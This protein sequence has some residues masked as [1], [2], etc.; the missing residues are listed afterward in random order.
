MHIKPRGHIWRLLLPLLVLVPLIAAYG[1]K[2]Q[3]HQRPRPVIA[4]TI[5]KASR[6]QSGRIFLEHAQEVR[7]MR[8]DSFMVLVGDVLFT[9][10]PMRMSCDSAHYYPDQESMNAFGNVKMQQ[11]DTLF[12][13]ADELNY[14]G[15]TEMA[16]LY[17][18]DGRSVRMINR[19]VTLTTPEF[20]YDLGSDI[21]YYTVGGTLTDL[22][23]RLTSV[24]GEYTPRTKEANFYSQVHL[25]SLS[26]GDTVNIY[27]DTLYYNTLTH[28]A[29]FYSPTTIV[30]TQATMWST[31]GTYNTETTVADFYAHSRVKTR[32][33][34]T[35]EGDTLFYDRRNGYGEAFGNMVLTDSIKQ[36]TLMGDYGYYNELTD[37][38][39][40][41]GH[42]QAMEYSRGDTLY[43]HAGEVFTY[44]TFD[45]VYAPGDTIP[46][47]INEDGALCNALDSTEIDLG[48]T[49]IPRGTSLAALRQLT[50]P[51]E[52][53]LSIDTTH[54][55]V[56]HPRVRF[57]R[58]D[59][60]GLCDSMQFEERD[61]LLYM[62]VKPV[63]WSENRQIFGNQI[64]VH[65]NDST[66][67][68]VHLPD[69][70][71]TAQHV[72]EE[73]YNQLAG[74][75]MTAYMHDGDLRHLDVDGNVQAIFL[76][77]EDDSTYN[78][79]FFIESSTLAADFLNREILKAKFW[80][81]STS[82]AT[83]LFLAKK[84]QY[85]LPQFKWYDALRPKD[86]QDIF[87]YPP[88]MAELLEDTS[89]QQST[90][91][92]TPTFDQ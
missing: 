58:S 53:I 22:R 57:Y 12:V 44:Q 85:Y 61:T 87:N 14:D 4:P 68:R 73:F 89:L 18:S 79:L 24:E 72:D 31:D 52:E 77:Q 70:G 63:V 75:V 83:P 71:L 15:L 35:L 78:K 17:G 5:P 9:K 90:K 88:G 66:V 82:T 92:E 74:K 69:F 86:P 28:Q 46:V 26:Q 51:S 8:N 60:Q 33:G 41:T 36:S 13:Y 38:A 40:V 6:S 54:I 56:A 34:A 67:D 43:I 47:Y 84:A 7:K 23:N 81:S 16:Y 59:L 2:P 1:A 25:H 3:G 21:G 39:Y 30:N 42:A 65:L 37:S 27:T 48:E 76:P 32:R 11:G 91:A 49:P 62:Y 45:T 10:G 55:M 50:L 64:Q 20:T 19:D 80:P 29:E